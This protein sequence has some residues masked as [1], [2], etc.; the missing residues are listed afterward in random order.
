VANVSFGAALARYR[1]V[2]RPLEVVSHP[3]VLLLPLLGLLLLVAVLFPERQDDEAGYLELARNLTHGHYAT[4]RP[5]ALL[6]ADPSYPDLW[7]GPGL[8]LVLVGPVAAGLP[9]ELIRLVGPLALFAALIVF[10]ALL[11]RSVRPGTAL[12]ATW[13][14]GLYLPFF[15]VLTNLHSEPLA[16]FFVVAAMYATARLLDDR[17]PVWLGVGAAALAGLAL[18]R[19]DYGWV[20]TVLLV[21]LLAWWGVAR[22]RRA[23]RLAGMLGLSLA[24]CVPWLAYTASETGRVLVWGNSGSLSLY[25]MSSPESGD[26]GDWQQAND[27]FTNPNLAAHEPVFERLRG[28]DLPKQNAELERRAVENIVSHPLKY[29]ENIAANVSRMFF[30]APYS[31]TEQRLSAVFFALPNALLLSVALLAAVGAYRMRESL[32]AAAVPFGAFALVSFGLHALVAAYPRMLMPIVPVVV[33]FAA[34]VGENV[35]LARPTVQDS[36]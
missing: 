10:Y 12:A 25:W 2:W 27:V 9:I 13:A 16:V 21:G 15:S 6:D 17:S 30:D 26:L 29:A 35:R 1:R 20:N 28:L 7:F 19:V 22:S 8:P 24:L 11:L 5:D 34:T 4:G 23:R 3:L 14:L 31:Y 32:P 36:V 18:T 33:W